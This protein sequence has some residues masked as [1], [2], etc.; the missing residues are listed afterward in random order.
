MENESK[1]FSSDYFRNRVSTVEKDGKKRKWMYPKEVSGLFFKYRTALSWLLLAAFYA[2]PWIQFKEHQLLLLN[3]LERKFILFGFLIS[4]HDFYLVVFALLTGLISIVLFTVIYGRIFC[5]W[6]CPQT[7]FMEMVF[8]K[9]ETLFEGKANA[10]EKLDKA[11]M[12]G[13]K[14]VRKLLKHTTYVAIA[15]ITITTFIAYLIGTDTL[16][17]RYQD[18][19]TEHLFAWVATFAFTTAFYLVFA[20]MRELVCII[21]CPYGRLQGLLLD[22]NSIVVAYDY[23]RGE[24]RG[25][26]QKN[27]QGE[28]V[29][30]GDCIDCGLCFDVCPTGIDI[31][32]GTQLECVNCT[33]CIDVCDEVMD[34]IKR[35]RRLIGYYSENQIAENIPFKMTVRTWSYSILLTVLFIASV[36]LVLNRKEVEANILRTPGTLYQE[37]ANN[38]ISNLY[39]YEIIN[40]TF[41][42]VEVVVRAQNPDVAIAIIGQKTIKIAPE[43]I[44]KGSLFL[45]LPKSSVN[46]YQMKLDLDLYING[47]I[48]QSIK[49]SFLG[50]GKR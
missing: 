43:S 2:M 44:A 47:E 16:I 32:N 26:I 21:A 3:I 17:K 39:N 8:R 40:K 50:G 25:K 30:K 24:P 1:N 34:K 12:D 49:T 7:I 13:N 41:K 5:G 11:P 23:Q 15:Y 18:P 48:N 33:A 27:T 35:P 20:K 38:K 4:P 42:P 6:I 19:F 37:Q 31:R 46:A 22:R 28:E 29:I 36:L 45:T 14:F 9:I 10:R